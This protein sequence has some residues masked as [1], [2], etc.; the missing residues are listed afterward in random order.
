MM[1]WPPPSPLGFFSLLSLGLLHFRTHLYSSKPR[2]VACSAVFTQSGG[3]ASPPG[4]PL[5]CYDES[6]Y[7]CF[8]L[9][10]E[11]WL[12][13]AGVF[14]FSFHFGGWIFGKPWSGRIVGFSCGIGDA[15]GDRFSYTP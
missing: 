12:P 7:L 14:V 10:F 15:I 9:I 5:P 4:F 8:V 1:R 2:T 13:G 6:F 11:D 3:H